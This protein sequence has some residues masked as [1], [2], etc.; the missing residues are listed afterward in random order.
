MSDEE[1]LD[2]IRKACGWVLEPAGKDSFGVYYAAFWRHPDKPGIHTTPDY[3]N[4]LNAMHGA[5][6]T[7]DRKQRIAFS[8]YLREV[9]VYQG[10]SAFKEDGD[11]LCENA[12]A[13]QRALAFIKTIGL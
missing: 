5:W 11:A 1:M 9:I 12:T 4:D 10:M 7:L 3:L 13:R 6:L 8:D 2:V